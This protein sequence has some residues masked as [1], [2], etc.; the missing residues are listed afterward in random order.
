M[1]IILLRHG[2]PIIPSLKKIKASS[3]MQWIESYNSSELRP[4]SKPNQTTLTRVNK[5]NSV[6][7]SQLIR[8]KQ[9][10][11]ALNIKNIT[12]SGSQFNEAGLPSANWGILKL[13]PNTWA[14]IFR[15]LWLFGYSKN[16]ESYKEAKLRASV[17]ANKLI[18][19]SKEHKSVLF[20]GHGIYNR[21]LA[22]ELKS[23]GWYGPGNPGSKYW[24]FG[25][26]QN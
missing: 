7:C 12:L 6:V 11:E 1:E 16:S 25:V 14:A 22:K 24:S 2:K 8:S 5:C 23:L 26:Y 20:V 19:L 18:E 10:A 21:L 3:F 13:S 4:T 9:S 15:I 17:S